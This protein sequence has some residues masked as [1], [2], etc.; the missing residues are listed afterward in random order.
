MPARSSDFWALFALIAWVVLWGESEADGDL[1]EFDRELRQTRLF[2]Q[3][4]TA[5]AAGTYGD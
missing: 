4:R 3:V 2:R 5:V 1:E